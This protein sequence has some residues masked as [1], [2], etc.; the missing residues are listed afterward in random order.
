[1]KKISTVEFKKAILA[2]EAERLKHPA[3]FRPDRAQRAVLQ[4]SRQASDKMMSAFLKETGL[5]LKKLQAVQGQRGAQLERM[6]AKQKTEALR[7]ASQR[8]D[9]LYS[10]IAGQ[11]KALGDLAARS[12][13]FPYPSFTLDTPFL[14]WSI[15]LAE[16]TDSAAVPFG[17]WAKFNFKE[18]FGGTQKFG[19]YFYWA[20]D[21]Q[22]YAVINAATFMSAT[23]HLRA[24]AP[25]QLFNSN[26][27][28]VKATAVLNLWYGWPTDV[29]ST[30]GASYLLG[31][32]RACSSFITGPDISGTSISSGVSLSRTLF[33]VPRGDVVVFEVVLE[34]DYSADVGG[35]IEADFA[36]GDFQIACPV[37]VVSLLNSPPDVMA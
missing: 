1:M 15:P 8:K 21:F 20:N 9:T 35:N 29:R 34:I 33:A 25:W 4:K 22:D 19:F 2:V 6:V 13:F 10:S 37:V 14:I 3:A 11:S 31:G 23:G 26:C 7:L 28:E 12:D 36:S 24:H 27:S 18:S 5:D 30:S 16:I 17:S 32:A